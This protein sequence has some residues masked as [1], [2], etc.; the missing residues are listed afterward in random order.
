MIALKSVYTTL[1][2]HQKLQDFIS[3]V[4]HV[5]EKFKESTPQVFT[6]SKEYAFICTEFEKI[7]ISGL[8]EAF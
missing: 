6:K 3:L 2:S 5:S 8:I 1:K 4:S 7:Q